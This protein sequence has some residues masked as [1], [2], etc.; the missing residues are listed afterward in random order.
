MKKFMGSEILI[1]ISTCTTNRKQK[2]IDIESNSDFVL[3]IL[4]KKEEKNNKRRN[5]CY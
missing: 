5:N 1:S 4:L 2:N 3:E